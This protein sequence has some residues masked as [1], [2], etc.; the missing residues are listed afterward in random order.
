MFLALGSTMLFC[1]C[2]SVNGEHVNM[3]KWT[4]GNLFKDILLTSM[5][6]YVTHRTKYFVMWKNILPRVIDECFFGWKKND[7]NK[8]DELSNE[9]WQQIKL[10]FSPSIIIFFDLYLKL[11]LFHLYYLAE[12]F[13]PL[14]CLCIYSTFIA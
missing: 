13:L 1:E 3:N 6:Y 14:P 8:M 9:H 7:L 12:S 4:Q 2:M 5:E 10:Q 11:H